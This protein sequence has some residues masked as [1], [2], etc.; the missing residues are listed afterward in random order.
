MPRWRLGGATY[1]VTWHLTQAS[2]TLSPNERTLVAS[3]I[4]HFNEERYDLYAYVVMDDHVHVLLKPKDDNALASIL[5]TWKSYT[6]H[7]ILKAHGNAGNIW[8][9]RNHTRIIRCEE[10]LHRFA[11]Y[12]ISNPA[13]R[14][15][16]TTIYEWLEWF[17]W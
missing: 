1:F 9:P 5:Y 12:I 8:Q 10:D 11:Q 2:S 6:A 7:E 15:P 3:A 13:K 17:P 16:G 4:K 14:W